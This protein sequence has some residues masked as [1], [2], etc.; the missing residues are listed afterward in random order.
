MIFSIMNFLTGYCCV[1]L[2]GNGQ[3]RFLNI[4]V[5]KRLLIWRLRRKDNH[6]CFLVSRAGYEELE[7]I[8]AKT[9]CSYRCEYK[10]GLP[11]LF[12]RYR[13]RKC[14]VAALLFCMAAMYVMSLFIWQIDT[15][16]CYSHSRE[17]LLDY[18]RE[19][20][21][22]SGMRISRLSC[23]TL[24]EKIREDFSDIAWVSCERKGTLLTVSVKETLDTAKAE[25]N[26]REP[27]NL[28]A[29]KNGT[30]ESIIVRSGTANVKKGDKVKP[31]DVLISGVVELHDDSGQ[32]TE[33]AQVAASGDIYAVT[34]LK[35]EDEFPL[36]YYE[37]E[38]TG[39]EKRQYQLL[40]GG[41]LLELPHGKNHYVQYD[42]QS[43][44]ILLHIGPQFYLPCSLI[45]TRVRECEIQKKKY[46]EKEAVREAEQRISLFLAEYEAKGVEILKNN[47]K[48]D[49]D[50]NQCIARGTIMIKERF[51]KV[52]K[53]DSTTRRGAKE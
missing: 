7:E 46:T 26:Q 5:S 50:K 41:Q 43:R 12:N 48:I 52:Q 35:Y 42:E 36:L 4:C 31:G 30:I 2:S 22:K 1:T 32:L 53:L 37:K 6:C 15:I 17:E 28:I 23:S 14:F 44:Q 24:E 33:T 25:E 27:C 29:S 40:W 11:F 18:L 47:V 20:G 39:N 45:E 51:G 38:Y 34:K 10:K 21:I 13:K 19:N 3:E 8:A 49:C 16:G 9:G